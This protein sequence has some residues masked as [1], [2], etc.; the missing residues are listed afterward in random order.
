MAG[1]INSLKTS[2]E[3]TL[4][5]IADGTYTDNFRITVSPL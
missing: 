5:F 1:S 4:V 2:L 3:L